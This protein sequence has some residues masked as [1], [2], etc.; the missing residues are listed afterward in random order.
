M[1]TVNFDLRYDNGTLL[2]TCKWAANQCAFNCKE[3]R[4]MKSVNVKEALEQ[5]E[6]KRRA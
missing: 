4:Q 6:V 3:R 2:A 1:M 5:K